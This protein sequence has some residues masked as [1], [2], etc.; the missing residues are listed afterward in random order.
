MQHE[1]RTI[2]LENTTHFQEIALQKALSEG[3][4]IALW[5]LPNTSNQHLII[6]CSESL[7]WE[8]PDLEALPA[9]FLLSP[10]QSPDG[11]AYF[12]YADLHYSSENNHME[13]GLRS[14]KM[15]TTFAQK[16]N[17]LL[18]K[19]QTYSP[20]EQS[21]FSSFSNENNT[22]DTEKQHYT[23]LVQKGIEAIEK[24]E[25][26]KVVLSRRKKIN[27]PRNFRLSTVFQA[28]CQT[29]PNAFVSLISIP[30]VGI[31]LGASPET[32]VSLDKKGIFRTVALAGTQPKGDLTN[33]REARWSQKEIEEQALVS[34][35]IINCFKKIRLREFEEL[36]PRTV[37]AANLLH[38]RTDFE[39]DTQALN[40]PELAS[41]M[42]ELLHPTSAVC[43]MPKAPSLEFIQQYEGYDR[44]L[45]SGFLGQVNIE[46]ETH[47]F[48]N[49]R[50]M[51]VFENEAVLY[52]GAGITQDSLP[53]K[54][55]TETEQKCQTLLSV[56]QKL[57]G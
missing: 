46:Q 31:W 36:G 10:F 51:Q 38:L 20:N 6:D 55:W 11:K 57:E 3:Q 22:Q 4:S 35:Y 24:G 15:G 28:L 53:E 14:Q 50:C 41:V 45:Y 16:A 33:L 7:F 27:L 1:P 25:F 12:L 42:L 56:L 17:H 18:D 34:R 43:G 40:F 54:E 26:L 2:K 47:L 32:L 13:L 5:R 44:E 30:N 8:K 9:G 48:V 19:I 52:A 39:V 49:L 37:E 29:Y 21:F 23:D